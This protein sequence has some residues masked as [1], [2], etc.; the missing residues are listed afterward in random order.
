MVLDRDR[1]DH[2]AATVIRGPVTLRDAC[3]RSYRCHSRVR[4]WRRLGNDHC[5]RADTSNHGDRGS[6]TWSKR[7]RRGE[8][9]H[10]RNRATDASQWGVLLKVALGNWR[11]AGR[12]WRGRYQTDGGQHDRNGH[13]SR[14]HPQRLRPAPKELGC[15]HAGNPYQC[16]NKSR[17]RR[18][19][20][21]TYESTLDMKISMRALRGPTP[22]AAAPARAGRSPHGAGRCPRG[23]SSRG[24]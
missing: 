15:M 4:A 17:H 10:H 1:T 12:C 24:G 18:E 8:V 3:D 16:A 20:A 7:T 11:G 6:G 5:G 2:R 14:V 13:H 9:V 23:E 22:A 21:S 19:P